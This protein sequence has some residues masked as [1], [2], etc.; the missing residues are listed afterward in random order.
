VHLGIIQVLL[1]LDRVREDHVQ[2]EH[3]VLPHSEMN[4]TKKTKPGELAL[5]CNV[6]TDRLVY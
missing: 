4:P 1:H 3:Q 5:F 6:A 2:V